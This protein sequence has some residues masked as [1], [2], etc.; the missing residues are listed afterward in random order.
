MQ[1]QE[2]WGT[3]WPPLT[4]A[5]IAAILRD[6][7]FTVEIRD[8]PSSNIS[9]ESLKHQ[10]RSFQPRMIIANTATPS[11][12]GDLKV[13]ELAKKIDTDIKTV[14]FGIHVSALAEETFKENPNVEFIVKGEPEYTLKDLALALKDKGN[15][16]NVKGLIYKNNG[17]II[18]NEKRPFIDNLDELPFPAWDLININNYR[19]PLTNKPFL[20]VLTGRA[21]SK[22][23]TF[24]ATEVFYGKKTRLRSW[25]KVVAEIKYIKEKYGINDFLFWSENSLANREQIYNISKG[26][27]REAPGTRWL[28]NGRVDMVD[29]ELLKIMKKSGCWMIGFGIE[30]GTQRVLDLMKKNITIDNIKMA[31]KLAKKA[32]IEVTGHAIIGYPGETK[33][34]ILKTINLVK[35]IK[36]DYLQVY[37]CVPFP[38][39]WLY[40]SLKKSG[41]IKASPWF[42]YE[43]NF[44]VINTPQLS[45]EEIM[46]LREKIVKNFYFTPYRILKT[47]F[48]LRSLKELASLISFSKRYFTFW[49]KA[50]NKTSNE[51]SNNYN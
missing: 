46:A 1:R 48:K 3:S 8:C 38:G 19:L 15:L 33:N 31:V 4:L 29:K 14:F 26:L 7:G 50:K 12:V 9:F 11:I 10:I 37:C 45:A 13:A 34:D 16:K 24:C 35:K 30:A 41:N 23:C 22:G 25:G 43:Q 40:T 42:M 17:E 2:A 51:K 5:I 32:G 21:C 27:L 39:S 49:I 44:S 47:V 18:Y 20:L 6:T 36:L 28:C